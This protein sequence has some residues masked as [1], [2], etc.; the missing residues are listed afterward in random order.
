MQEIIA[1]IVTPQESQKFIEFVERQGYETGLIPPI[2]TEMVEKGLKLFF[3]ETEGKVVGTFAISPTHPIKVGKI[4]LK[5]SE[6]SI[7]T[8]VKEQ[9]ASPK[10]NKFLILKILRLAEEEAR[11]MKIKQ[12][13]T[14]ISSKNPHWRLTPK[15][16]LKGIMGYSMKDPKSLAEWAKQL[17]GQLVHPNRGSFFPMRK[18]I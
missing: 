2:L 17:P 8:I 9:R 15:R 14:N 18:K 6:L 7:V 12:L 13:Q 16:A 1:R 10:N 5:E 11:K 4:N 3:V